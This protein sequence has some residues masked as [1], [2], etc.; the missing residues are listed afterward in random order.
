MRNRYTSAGKIGSLVL[1]GILAFVSFDLTAQSAPEQ[2]LQAGLVD[3][4]SQRIGQAGSVVDHSVTERG[5]SPNALCGGATV[6]T[7]PLGTPV[8]VTGNN[9]GSV[10]DPIIS[11]NVVWE[12]FT[13]SACAS[14]T[15]GYC[16]TT[17]A[18]TGAL[19]TL[20]VG[21]PLTN[22]AF[23]NLSNV[24]PDACGDGNFAILFPDLPAG[25]YYYPVL[26]GTGAT[27][28][29]SLTFTATACSTTFPAN[30]LCNGAIELFPD[31]ACTPVAGSVEF[32]TRAGNT[33]GGCGNSDAAD[34][35]WYSFTATTPAQAITVVPSAQFSSQ[36]QVFNG[37]C[38][39]LTALSCAVGADFGITSSLGLD[40]L[41]VGATY[42][43]RVSDWYSG[44][45]RTPTFTICIRSCDAETGTLTADEATVCYAGSP[46]TISATEND[47]PAV[48]S[49]FVV[50]Y[51][52]TSGTGLVIEATGTEASFEVDATGLYT[53]HTL[54]Y[55]PATLDLGTIVIGETTGGDV[56]AL[57]VQGGG[58]ICGSL[59]L[60]GAAVTVQV[61]GNCPAFAG[62][63][64]ADEATV[65]Y[66][67][68]PV[69]ISA[70]PNAVPTIPAGFAAVFV[71]TV[72]SDLVIVATNTVPTFTVPAVGQYRI[73]TLVYDPATLALGTI[74][75]G[76]TTGGDV[77]GL[78]EQGGGSICASLDLV[79]AAVTVQV[80]SNCP[81]FAGT[82]TADEATVCY[83]GDPVTISAAQNVAPTTP[84]G[85]A[86]IYVLTV[87]SDLV[88]VATNTVPSFTVP[89]LGQYRIHTLVYDPATLDL[90]IVVLGQTTGGEVS[91]LLEQ[92]GGTICGSLDVNGAA[93]SVV[94][95]S[96]C[97]ADAGTLTA[98]SSTVCFV[99]PEMIISATSNGDV[100]VPLGFETL[101]LLTS[102]QDLVIEGGAFAEPSFTVTSVGDYTIHTLIFD[103]ATLDLG[104]L[105]FGES[106]AGEVN[107]LLIQGGGT[108]CASLD[109]VGAPVTVQV[110]SNC[111]ADAGTLTADEATVC[112]EGEPVIISATQN[113]EPTIPFGFGTVYVLT[114]GSDL[115]IVAT[116][117]V[118]TFT[119]PAIGQYRI[120]TLV[121]D[122]A[123]LDLG[124]IVLGETTGGVVSALLQQGGG[125]ICG[126]LDV[127]GAPVVVEVCLPPC[128][129]YAGTLI[130]ATSE[131]CF[132][133]PTI[134]ANATS[135][136]DAVVPVGFETLYLLTSG[137]DL[138]IVQAAL[139]P[140]FNIG[141]IGE[142]TMHTLVYDPATLDLGGLTFGVSTAGEV[143]AQLIQGGGTICASLDV[144]GAPVAVIDC[145]PVND[146][147]SAAIEIPINAEGNCPNGS[148]TGN[149]TY[150]TEDTGNRP[151]CDE[152]AVSFADVWYTFN[153]GANTEVT[154]GFDPLSME[155]WGLTVSDACTGG[156]DL[157]CEVAPSLPLVITTTENTTYW[158]RVFTNVEFGLGG[159]FS[160]CLSGASPT[161]ICDGGAVSDMDSETTISVCQDGDAD[162]IDFVTSSTS[163]ESYAY[164]VTDESNVIVT[165]MSGN[166]LDFNALLSGTYRVW[167]ISYN[168]DLEGA[169]PGSIATAV[170]STGDCLELSSNFVAVNVEVCS[171]I[172]INVADA[173]SIFPNPTNGIFNVRFSGAQGKA[174]IEL[175]DMGGRLVVQGTTSVTNGQVI[176]F[177]TAGRAVPGLYTVR[178]TSASGVQNVRLVVQ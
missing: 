99:A 27:G 122:P 35:V 46:I 154:L 84:A 156:T 104:S 163:V 119:V 8:T 37:D 134:T 67:G 39:A 21:C 97:A 83:E 152:T 42:Y 14:V 136:N 164:V 3:V 115:V 44:A 94:V 147:C 120:H 85:F 4:T 19:I 86:A 129:A 40:D 140:A 121:Y 157:F 72:S 149:T 47:A 49:G 113:D 43:V 173:W 80:C 142:Y 52:L 148:I 5:G 162:V 132:L 33:G 59:D 124:T 155:N 126:S 75:L 24:I 87:S 165:L 32:A 139:T 12:G 76:Q 69:T 153:S 16:G 177:N 118:P 159:E 176:T 117:T 90:G 50:A 151:T 96:D 1:S 13:T 60:M 70:T 63:L 112:Y 79:G 106:T 100:V 77:N 125:A 34:G 98:T 128:D 130:D 109:L 20:T 61:C 11:A 95:C 169:G 174:V 65:C 26:Q 31:A 23:N 101:Y 111:A 116:N 29:Y 135:N 57:L 114:A 158:V 93:V 68:G 131:I 71:L 166:S 123:T 160:L 41:T 150:A 2:R 62:T 127:V 110:C 30:A 178:L 171:G 78:L 133:A 25:T 45:P 137:T 66:E 167:G 7:L 54:V 91:A 22:L 64:T 143:L 102:G 18:F 56:N 170:T 172:A 51:V 175:L 89:A 92:G 88:I 36:F 108:I 161:F 103:P 141:A 144:A 28:P 17:P 15:V 138:V 81:A 107:V 82:L 55:D 48:P 6:V 146:D 9:S 38:N 53:I 58:A 10:F 74:V 145:T 105:V 168:G 73:H